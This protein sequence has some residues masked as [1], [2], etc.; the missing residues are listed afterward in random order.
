MFLLRKRL[1]SRVSKW[2]SEDISTV[3][4]QLCSYFGSLQS[5]ISIIS[6][7]ILFIFT[8]ILKLCI[9][10][11]WWVVTR[12]CVLFSEE[13]LEETSVDI[14]KFFSIKCPELWKSRALMFST[15]YVVSNDSC[16]QYSDLLDLLEVEI[17]A[18]GSSEDLRLVFLSVVHSCFGSGSVV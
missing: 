17:T 13:I 2:V 16:V 11:G 10:T 12:L 1:M 3:S 9:L 5:E 15:E 14:L 4:S 6:H 8:F 18:L 7:K